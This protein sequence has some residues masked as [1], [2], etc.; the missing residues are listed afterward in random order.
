MQKIQSKGKKRQ[1]IRSDS[2]V[3]GP[4]ASCRNN[5]WI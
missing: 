1:E 4:K 3:S 2:Y 5:I